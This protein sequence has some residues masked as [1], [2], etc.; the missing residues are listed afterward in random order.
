MIAANVAVAETLAAKGAPCMYRVHDQPPLDKLQP[1]REFLGSL[2][3]KLARS[4]HVTPNQFNRILKKV[5]G[6]SESHVI[7]M[8]I[9]R[10]QSQAEYSPHN[11][12]HFGLGLDRYAHFTSPIRRYADLL[13]HRALIRALKLGAG[14]LPDNAAAGF[15]ELGA[16]ISATERRAAKAERDAFDRY[17]TRFLADHVGAELAGRISGVTRF[18]LF[19]TLDEAGADGLIP[20]RQLG[21][22]GGE[23]FHHDEARH[24]LVGDHS[25]TTFSLGQA[26]T[27]RLAEADV[28]TGSLRFEPVGLTDQGQRSSARPH[29]GRRARR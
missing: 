5:A 23:Y 25:G 11:I 13:V 16:A 3:H 1:L 6:T 22:L 29:R 9:L 20:M 2:G 26:I 21:A 7:S 4:R 14:G 17:A 27:V 15:D 28:V 18:G 24:R 10:A 12:G 19:V 8:V